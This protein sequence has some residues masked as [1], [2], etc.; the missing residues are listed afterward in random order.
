MSSPGTTSGS[1]CVRLT[2]AIL[3]PALALN[4]RR[5][6]F[7]TAARVISSRSLTMMCARIARE[8]E[9]RN[10]GE[11]RDWVER[12]VATGLLFEMTPRERPARPRLQISLEAYGPRFIGELN[13]NVT[14]PPS[15][16]GGVRTSTGVV[17]RQS[18]VDIR[19]EPGVK[20][21]IS[22]CVLQHIYKTP[23]F[24]HARSTAN[25]MPSGVASKLGQIFT[26]RSLGWQR[27]PTQSRRIIVDSASVVRRARP[28]AKRSV[29]L[30]YESGPPT[31]HD[32][33]R[34]A[35]R[36]EAQGG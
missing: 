24:D 4:P 35:C 21:R 2:S 19:R 13:D 28:P 10:E 8:Q 16:R 33:R 22:V 36:A 20:G 18:R 31:C 6:A 5:P 29:V 1:G 15:T 3:I 17:R 25:G 7:I 26:V 12:S 34:V 32:S 23:G 9:C 27:L 14:V 30:G 11:A